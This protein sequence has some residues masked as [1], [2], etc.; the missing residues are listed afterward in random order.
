M[1]KIISVKT[2]NP[3]KINLSLDLNPE[4]Y[5]FLEGQLEHINVFGEGNLKVGTK[6]VQ[7]G[8]EKST[9]YFLLPK[10]FKKNLLPSTKVMCNRIEKKTKNIF[11]FEVPKY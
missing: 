9:K 2:T 11:I 10:A 3:D 8:K 5:A 6:L 1:A 7:R 4:E